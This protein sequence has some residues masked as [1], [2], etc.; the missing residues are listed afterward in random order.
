MAISKKVF[1]TEST[2]F[3]FLDRAHPKH[4]QAIAFFRY[5]AQEQYQLYTSYTSLEKTCNQ[6]VEKVSIPL[7]KDFL[8]AINLGLINIIYPDESDI[9]TTIKTLVNYPTELTFNE[10][11]ASVLADKR[12][13]PQICTFDYL[14]PLFGLKIFYL[15]I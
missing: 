12:A 11:L 3:A 9:K 2:F 1:I 6:I 15:P 7:A 10:A 5:F 14:Q 13:I 8:R 4:N